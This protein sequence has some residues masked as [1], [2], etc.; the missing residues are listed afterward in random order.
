VCAADDSATHDAPTPLTPTTAKTAGLIKTEEK[1]RN[2]RDEAAQETFT[3]PNESCN[4]IS[5]RS[6]YKKMAMNTI[7]LFNGRRTSRR[8]TN[9]LQPLEN[10]ILQFKHL[11]KEY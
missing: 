10:N 3:S 5:W 9:T 11:L 6:C 7:T 1:K 2:P 8:S 4:S